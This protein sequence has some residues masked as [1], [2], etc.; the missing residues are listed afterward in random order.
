MSDGIKTNNSSA[1]ITNQIASP[2]LN[3]GPFVADDDTFDISVRFYRDNKKFV[4]EGI[5]ED[6]KKDASNIKE[7]TLTMKYPSQGDTSLI[8]AQ[9]RQM[10]EKIKVENLNVSDFLQVEVIRFLT[11]VRKWNRPEPLDNENLM[12]LSPKIIRVILEKIRIEIGIDGII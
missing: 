3:D 8:T 7:L 4:V 10:N 2:V 6:F 5:D 9:A 11:Q 12:N 1:T